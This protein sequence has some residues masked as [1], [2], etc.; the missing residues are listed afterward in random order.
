MG[1]SLKRIDEFRLIIMPLSMTTNNT[2]IKLGVGDLGVS[3]NPNGSIKTFALGSCVALF[4]L[5]IESGAV[6]MG[7]IAL[8][9]SNTS[10]EKARILPGSEG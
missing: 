6:G 4:I 10:P 3:I 2:E 8:P 1:A 5:D 9:D 7:H